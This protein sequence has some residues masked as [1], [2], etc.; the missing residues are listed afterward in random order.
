M[1]TITA[2]LLLALALVGC[3]RSPRPELPAPAAGAEHRSPDVKGA[4]QFF[5]QNYPTVRAQRIDKQTIGVI[6]ESGAEKQFEV[7]RAKVKKD[8][9]VDS[10][11]TATE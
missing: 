7:V 2:L 1:K 6:W 9:D 11:I 4:L 3:N 8:F 5:A 10:V